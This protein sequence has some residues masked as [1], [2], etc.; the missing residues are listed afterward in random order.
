MNKILKTKMFVIMIFIYLS[1]F[2]SNDEPKCHATKRSK[3]FIVNCVDIVITCVF[4]PFPVVYSVC[5]VFSGVCV[6]WS[7]ARRD[8]RCQPR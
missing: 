8:G 2:N 1:I 5:C 6:V 3:H 4:F 7:S